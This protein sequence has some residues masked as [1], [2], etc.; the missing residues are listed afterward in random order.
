MKTMIAVAMAPLLLFPS[1][2]CLNGAETPNT[3]GESSAWLAAS[4]PPLLPTMVPILAY[5]FTRNGEFAPESASSR[6]IDA[7]NGKVKA[8]A[9]VRPLVETGCTATL[10][11]L[12]DGTIVFHGCPT[13]TCG[14]YQ[15]I[16]DECQSSWGVGN[17]MV[18]CKCRHKGYFGVLC[19][20][21]VSVPSQG[22][23]TWDCFL[24]NCM[25]EEGCM[26]A[27]APLVGGLFAGC[28][29]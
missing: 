2:D 19:R 14:F 7:A 6:D 24:E 18:A 21:V 29:C 4:Q 3:A 9:A 5:D 17:V 8:Y 23:V 10:E 28:K 22:S 12:E 27:D 20:A 25:S 15:G 16:A 26:K 1:F 13:Y 11:A